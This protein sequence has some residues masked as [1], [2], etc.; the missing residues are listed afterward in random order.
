MVLFLREVDSG[1]F[2]GNLGKTMYE[3]IYFSRNI[4]LLFPQD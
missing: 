4:N 1:G 2:E 3:L